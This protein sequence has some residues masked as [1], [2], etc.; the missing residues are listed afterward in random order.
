MNLNTVFNN[1]I[2]TDKDFLLHGLGLLAAARQIQATMDVVHLAG[3]PTQVFLLP[4]EHVEVHQGGHHA[5]AL[6][7]IRHIG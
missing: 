5:I 1:P 2:E 6:G 3:N 7:S 4:G